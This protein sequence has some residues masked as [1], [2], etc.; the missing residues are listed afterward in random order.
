MSAHLL[1]AYTQKVDNDD[2]PVM[3]YFFQ[4]RGKAFIFSKAF[5]FMWK[6]F[7]LVIAQPTMGGT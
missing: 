3:T 1:H 7:R 6:P 5:F 4:M 2:K